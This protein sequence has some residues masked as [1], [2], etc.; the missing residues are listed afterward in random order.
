M[1]LINPVV[2]VDAH[3]LAFSHLDGVIAQV[4]ETVE[5]PPPVA[6][7]LALYKAGK[8]EMAANKWVD[9]MIATIK[10]LPVESGTE[11]AQK[12]EF[13]R[14]LNQYRPTI[15]TMLTALHQQ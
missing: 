6:E 4:D 15:T 9:S 2:A 3:P 12:G 1:L 5:I 13:L 11:E 7:G 14:I 10:D 8:V